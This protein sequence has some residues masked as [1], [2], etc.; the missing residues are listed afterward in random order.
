[1]TS[2]SHSRAGIARQIRRM[3]EGHEGV[4]LE[5]DRDTALQLAERFDELDRWTVL[6]EAG[7][8][9]QARARRALEALEAKRAAILA[10]LDAAEAR[11]QR[12]FAAPAPLAA[13]FLAGLAVGIV[14]GVAP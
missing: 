6:A 14:L 4:V 10:G 5:L 12:L 3:C 7:A 1:M 9:Q 2:A 11:A 13:A 8:L